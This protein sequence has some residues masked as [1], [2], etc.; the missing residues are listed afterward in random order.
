MFKLEEFIGT[1]SKD[2]TPI[3]VIH[4]GTE[5]DIE[6]GL[7]KRIQ[8]DDVQGILHLFGHRKVE[9]D[10]VK[11][12]YNSVTETIEIHIWFTDRDIKGE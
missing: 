5:E 2:E 1:M 10:S 6:H 11:F 8:S 12:K 4:W 3:Y 9:Y 7:E